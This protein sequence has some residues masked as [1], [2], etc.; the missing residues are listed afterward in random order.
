MTRIVLLLLGMLPFLCC[1]GGSPLVKRYKKLL[2]DALRQVTSRCRKK[3]VAKLRFRVNLFFAH[4]VC[5]KSTPLEVLIKQVDA[6]KEAGVDGLDINMG[7]YPW[8]DEDKTVIEKY[9]KLIRHIRKSGLA[10][11]INPV[12][13]RSYHK[14]KDFE[15]FWRKAEKVYL[16]IARRYRPDIFVL[17]HEPTTQNKRMGFVVKPERWA[18]FVRKMAAKIR[19]VSPK[20]KLGA[21]VHDKE[22][23]YFKHLVRIE[24]LR[25]ISFDIYNL[26]G[27]KRINQMIGETIDAGKLV[28]I[29]ET[30]RP[31]CYIPRKG[32]SFD[33]IMAKGIGL[34]EFAE[35]D[36]LWLEMIVSFASAW[37]MEAVTPFWTQ[38]FFKY[39]ERG[40]DAL[41]KDYNRDV[42]AA[43]LRG[44]R[45][46]TFHKFRELIKR[47][48]RDSRWDDIR[49]PPFRVKNVRFLR[50]NGGRVDW[51]HR[52]NLIAFDAKGADGF[53]DLYIMRPNGTAVT[54]LTQRI[55]ELPQRHIGNPAWHPSGK[56]I[57]F[58]AEE[59][60]HYNPSDR[61]VSNP[62][63]GCYNNL[64]VIRLKDR[65]PFKLTNYPVKKRS[66]DGVVVKAV[67]NARFWR[68]GKTLIWTER[69]ADGGLWGKWRIM[70]ADFKAQ[71]A[72]HLENIR[73][74]FQPQKGMGNYCTAMDI[75]KD[76][77]KLLLAGNLSGS[78]HHEYG[79]DIYILDLKTRKLTNLTNSP[80]LWEESA[81]F[82]PD[83]EWVLFMRNAGSP[84]NRKDRNW[85]W[86]KRRREYWMVRTDG[87]WCVQL[88]HFNEAG[89]AGYVGKPVIVCDHAWGPDGKSVVA[90]VGV[91]EGKGEKADFH[92]KIAL[93][94]L[95]EEPLKRVRLLMENEAH[96]VGW[97]DKNRTLAY[98]R[99]GADRF[100]DI[101]LL[102]PNGDITPLTSGLK[103]LPQ[104]HNGCPAWHPSGKYI[105]FGC[106]M[107]H[108][109]GPSVLSE[110]GFGVWCNLYIMEVATRR[111][112]KL[113]NL[114]ADIS[115]RGV[116]HP[117]F[118]P[119]GKKVVWAERIGN[120]KG[121]GKN[122][123]EWVIR[124][125]DLVFDRD[126]NPHLQNIK[127]YAPGEQKCWYETHGF[128]PD[129]SKIIFSANAEKGRHPTDLD[130]YTLNLKTGK[131]TNLTKSPGVWDEHAHY[132]PDGKWIVWMSSA[133]YPYTL[134][135]RKWKTPQTDLRTDLWLMRTDTKKRL[136]LTHFNEKGH[137][138]FMGHT[139]IGDNTWADNGKALIVRLM[140]VTTATPKTY[141]IELWEK[142][143]QRQKQ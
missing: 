38:P 101:F 77:E 12:Y 71:P 30:W 50:E 29:E 97:C 95:E 11:A 47:Y 112:W 54:C 123:G 122:W 114:P 62:G 100:F 3:A 57:V 9:D 131:L 7:L 73:V 105:L 90:L 93:I 13:S 134:D 67:V 116:L 68:D 87:S 126:G 140:N 46:A 111:F 49:Y 43:V 20:T 128:S 33:A 39:V 115:G 141:R 42:M 118:S 64:W 127:T 137:A 65:K 66:N 107:E 74:L 133:G 8:L 18:E 121:V 16:E 92:L 58:Q 139:I 61:W 125:A 37:G 124:L 23:D 55:A 32:E 135:A 136:R 41:S 108:H 27:L 72:P 35:T 40:G 89:F 88:T 21:G 53:Y 86:Q 103:G 14:I 99:R 2:G 82:S 109:P 59:A 5:I 94:E 143:L 129:G 138:E 24:A 104:K 96:R 56:Y 15:D 80:H 132:S 78:N 98:D 76:G 19:Q 52:N 1:A 84:L 31:P 45:T 130:I 48:G 106:E 17:V 28:Y 75:S 34:A 22:Y 142:F 113:T 70:C 51:C 63:I 85:F 36:A 119:D 44:E 25:Y 79:M 83:G 4:E 60:E 120:L 6:F 110:P 91:D 102:K 69:Y 81:S 10:L 26:R 117:H